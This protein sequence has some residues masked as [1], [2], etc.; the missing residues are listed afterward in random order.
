MR[1]VHI[2]FCSPFLPYSNVYDSVTGEKIQQI[3]A[4]ELKLTAS[5]AGGTGTLHFNNGITEHVTWW[6]LRVIDNQGNPVTGTKR[7]VVRT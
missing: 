1:Q 6:P 7:L 3:S 4:L 5:D 2:E